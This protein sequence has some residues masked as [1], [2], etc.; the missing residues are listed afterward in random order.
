M[1][2]GA[3]TPPQHKTGNAQRGSSASLVGATVPDIRATVPEFEYEADS[4]FGVL[5][6]V[7]QIHEHC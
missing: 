7:Y 4:V 2:P 3:R 5:I 1:L 6:S